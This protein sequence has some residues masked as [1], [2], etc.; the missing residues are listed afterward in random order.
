MYERNIVNLTTI[1]LTAQ[2]KRFGIFDM[3]AAQRLQLAQALT[4]TRSPPVGPQ[5]V[6]RVNVIVQLAVLTGA[7]RALIEAPS[8]ML[9]MVEDELERRGIRPVHPYGYTEMKHV[10]VEDGIYETHPVYRMVDV[11]EPARLVQR[12]GPMV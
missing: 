1:P 8:V 7:K 6:E 3:G 10:E 4:L 11:T 9:S 5:Y 2:M 12:R